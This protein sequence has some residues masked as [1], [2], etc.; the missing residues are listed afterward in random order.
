MRAAVMAAVVAVM[1]VAQEAREGKQLNDAEQKYDLELSFP[2]DD[3][4][5]TNESG[6]VR[7]IDS[8]IQ[9][10]LLA[11]G[12]NLGNLPD[13]ELDPSSIIF[14]ESYRCESGEVV[15]D[16]QCVPCPP[17]PSSRS[18]WAARRGAPSAPSVSSTPTRRSAPVG[19][20]GPAP[21]ATA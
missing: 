6:A 18:C 1:A 17:A 20:A 14:E 7:R 11:T 3:V 12:G 15:V 10:I 16:E 19:R 5:A 8:L 21:R 9:E 2:V 13:T 4:E